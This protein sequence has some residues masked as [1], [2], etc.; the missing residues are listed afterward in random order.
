[1]VWLVVATVLVTGGC[2]V[3]VVDPT[4]ST[5]TMTD[6]TG[7][8]LVGDWEGTFVALGQSATAT[9][10]ADGTY[11]YVE[12]T[13]AQDKTGTRYA[14]EQSVEGSY[15]VADETLTGVSSPLVRHVVR[16]SDG[17]PVEPGVELDM[18]IFPSWALHLSGASTHVSCDST[19]LV[20]TTVFAPPADMLEEWTYSR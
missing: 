1:M 7:G 6:S 15:Q 3:D 14:V 13:V 16:E 9:F 12:E 20:L 11:T 4:Q 5:V 8:C 2:T 17:A 18:G 10:R 19:A